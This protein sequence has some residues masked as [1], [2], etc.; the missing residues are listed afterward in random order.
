MGRNVSLDNLLSA[1]Y[2]IWFMLFL[3]H[4]G[5]APLIVFRACTKVL[6]IKNAEPPFYWKWFPHLMYF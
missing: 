5:I 4:G 2:D 3:S 6:V 1:Q